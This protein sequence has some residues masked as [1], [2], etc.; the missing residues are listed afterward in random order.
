MNTDTYPVQQRVLT[1]SCT[2]STSLYFSIEAF[3]TF[4]ENQ[5][6][7]GSVWFECPD[8]RNG[9]D[10]LI[11]V[12]IEPL[13][14]LEV[15]N[16]Q[17][18]AIMWGQSLSKRCFSDRESLWKFINE[19][20]DQLFS[21]DR[22][23]DFN[24]VLGFSSY[25]AL[26]LMEDIEL[27]DEG[28]T[29]SVPWL[30]FNLYRYI[31]VYNPSCKKVTL[32]NNYAEDGH[33]ELDKMQ[34]WL[35]EKHVGETFFAVDKLIESDCT[36]EEFLQ[37]VRQA[38]YHCQIG[39][40]FQLVVSRKFTRKFQGNPWYFFRELRESSTAPYYF[41]L[42]ERKYVIT[43]ASPETHF[44]SVDNVG[45]LN[46]IAGTYKRAVTLEEDILTELR[47][48]ADPK[49]NA[50]HT[51]LVDLARNDLSRNAE[52]VYVSELKKIE[53][54]THVMHI[55]SHVRGD[56]RETYNP[57]GLLLDFLP[58]GTLSGAPKYRAIQLINLLESSP[59][60][61]YGGLLGWLGLNK[62]LN[63]CILIRSALFAE[64]EMTYRAGA[65]VVVSS[66]PQ[67]ELEEVYNKLRSIAIALEKFSQS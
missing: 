23:N 62:N 50:E 27:R 52:N 51:M 34:Q 19:W 4:L 3:Y 30:K 14:Y 29:N 48:R 7:A 11:F 22:S 43:G 9:D 44:K 63:T 16:G 41:Y 54:Y 21:G 60:G 13:A 31:Y 65:G 10:R 47:L 15:L 36:E 1:A 49:E 33:S 55:V 35:S 18:A 61:Y 20:Q 66:D 37:K 26:Q 46:P 57:L 45:Y 56:L 32:V 24:G 8:V 40:V 2:V 42:N 5:S 39:D 53:R 6:A 59:R 67:T 64:G 58:A 38:K 17:T 12:A 28:A 25:D